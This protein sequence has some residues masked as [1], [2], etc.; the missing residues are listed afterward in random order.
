MI[1]CEHKTGRRINNS[2]VLKY[3]KLTLH[4]N[5]FIICRMSGTSSATASRTLQFPVEK[6][7]VS[8]V[9]RMEVSTFEQPASALARPSARY[10][11][12]PSP[13]IWG[14]TVACSYLKYVCCVF[15]TVV[16]SPDRV[17][18]TSTGDPH[19]LCLNLE[20]MDI[21]NV[22]IMQQDAMNSCI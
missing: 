6:S 3:F 21:E 14:W 4:F 2:I 20:E 15:I 5:T 7:I 9:K 1:W 17:L 19:K 22:H 16:S 13:L 10:R 8:K 18:G 11:W 12:K